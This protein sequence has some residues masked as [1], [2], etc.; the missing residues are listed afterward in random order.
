LVENDS[1][2]HFDVHCDILQSKLNPHD[3]DMNMI[4][5]ITDRTNEDQTIQKDFICV[6][7]HNKKTCCQEKYL[8]LKIIELI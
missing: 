6:Y 7:L 4:K 8:F 3:I 1:V 5:T 2:L